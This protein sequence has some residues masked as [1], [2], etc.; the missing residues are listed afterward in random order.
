MK[1][2]NDD[3]PVTYGMLKAVLIEVFTE[4]EA[5]IETRMDTKI[6]QS[7]ER[8]MARLARLEASMDAKLERLE[9]NITELINDVMGIT[10]TRLVKLERQSKRFNKGYERVEDHS[11]RIDQ[12]EAKLA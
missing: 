3:Q 8:M 9:Q 4:F 10:D 5:R 1:R 2:W 7:E 11:V 12:L 6:A